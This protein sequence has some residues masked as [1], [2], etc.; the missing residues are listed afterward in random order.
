M[1][2]LQHRIFDKVQPEPNS[3]CWLWTGATFNHGR[4]QLRMG[5]K[6]VLAA[7][8]AYQAFVGPIPEGMLACHKCD[9]PLCVNPAHLFLGT[10]QD[11]KD[12]CVAKNRQARNRGEKGSR[13][14]LTNEQVRAI[15]AIHRRGGIS[16]EAIGREFGVSGRQIRYIV[17]REQWAHIA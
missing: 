8:V 16:T 4:P 2:A 3:G 15:R 13:A 11:N 5:E 1:N 6:L 14:V 12:D 9:T 17:S 10:H 7:R